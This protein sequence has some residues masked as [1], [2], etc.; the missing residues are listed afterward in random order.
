MYTV[1]V[2][3][4]T[5]YIPTYMCI[6]SILIRRYFRVLY[7]MYSS[8]SIQFLLYNLHSVTF[9]LLGSQR[10]GASQWWVCGG[11]KLLCASYFFLCEQTFLLFLY[12]IMKMCSV[13]MIYIGI[14]DI[15]HNLYVMYYMIAYHFLMPFLVFA[16][17]HHLSKCFRF[18][19]NIR[20]HYSTATRL[21]FLISIVNLLKKM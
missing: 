15:I 3:I 1:Y 7:I 11:V 18:V 12:N 10:H 16:F 5:W 6:V 17:F 9:S 14:F 4:Y 19:D 21:H 2:H 8:T 13:P 20:W